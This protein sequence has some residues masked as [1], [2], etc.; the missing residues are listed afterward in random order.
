MNLFKL[1]KIQILN[2]PF[3]CQPYAER[4]NRPC[5]L[6]KH[7]VTWLY[8]INEYYNVPACYKINQ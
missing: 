2:E 5:N 7:F 1:H 8:I 6:S 4:I 3:P